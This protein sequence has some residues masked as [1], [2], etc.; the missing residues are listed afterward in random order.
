MFWNRKAKKLASER[1]KAQA[2]RTQE[3]L[4]MLVDV[5]IRKWLDGLTIEPDGAGFA[6]AEL[7]NYCRVLVMQRRT[8][9]GEHLHGIQIEVES[10]YA[11]FAVFHNLWVSDGTNSV[12]FPEHS[13]TLE[14]NSL[15][16][17]KPIVFS[18]TKPLFEG[19]TT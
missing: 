6:I 18:S 3:Q 19:P 5:H 7:G 1:E 4:Q 16:G 8:A 14:A 11:S 12:L 9:G 10:E 2:A 17:R 13:M 15:D